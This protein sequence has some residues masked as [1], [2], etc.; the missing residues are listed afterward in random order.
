MYLAV[1]TRLS[2]RR[3]ARVIAVSRH[4]AQEASKLLQV[5]PERLD[6]VHHGVADEFRPLRKEIIDEFRRQRS[7]PAQYVLYVGTLEPRKNLSR[8]VQAFAQT[9]SRDWGLVLAGG[10][11]WG[12]E[13]IVR[14]V[15]A[16]GIADRVLFA[17]YVPDSDLPLL[18]NAATVFAYPSLYEG[19]GMPVIE[20]MAC[21]LP[22]LTS[23]AS[24]LPE[25]AGD[26]AE[27]VDPSNVGAIAAGLARLMSEPDLRGELR[28]RGLA[29]AR[30]FDWRR[31]ARQT[32]QVYARAAG[33]D[34]L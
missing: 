1:L 33:W 15:Q 31:T 10:A 30:Q 6:V 12:Y 24:S 9:S 16:R 4:A 22:V 21:G 7:L 26:A 2:A 34:S 27:L 18:Y 20:A 25:V 28:K 17:G 8:L 13:S 29:R 32:A 19:F 14:D 23:K 3:A 5:P 11:G